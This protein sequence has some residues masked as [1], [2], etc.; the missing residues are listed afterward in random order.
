MTIDTPTHRREV[1][2][3]IRRDIETG[4]L[5]KK[6]DPAKFNDIA[7]ECLQR[8]HSL[9]WAISDAFTQSRIKDENLT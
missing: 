4:Q 5:S 3:L 1:V 9:A 2:R 6:Y 7:L 8:G